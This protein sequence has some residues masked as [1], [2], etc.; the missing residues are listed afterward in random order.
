MFEPVANFGKMPTYLSGSDM[1]APSAVRLFERSVQ[2]ARWKKLLGRLHGEFR[3]LEQ[4]ECFRPVVRLS[5]RHAEGVRAVALE[6]I[7]GSVDGSATFDS[8]FYPVNDRA[9]N[10]WVRV[11]TA[12]LQGEPLPPVELIQVGD[13]YYVM[14]GHHRISVARVLKYSHIDAVVTVWEV[15]GQREGGGCGSRHH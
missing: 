2:R 4:L 3:R 14:D 8:D 10:R 12:I 13:R 9:R 15:S 1:V 5:G 7:H 6:Q 11:A